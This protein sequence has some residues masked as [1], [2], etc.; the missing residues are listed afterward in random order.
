MDKSKWNLL[1]NTNKQKTRTTHLLNFTWPRPAALKQRWK[2][3]AKGQYFFP[4]VDDT[5]IVKGNTEQC[6]E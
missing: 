1:L 6:I 5:I 4:P 3:L 2:N